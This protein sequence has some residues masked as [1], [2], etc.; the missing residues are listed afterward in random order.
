MDGIISMETVKE[1]IV[2]IV[3][4]QTEDSIYDEILKEIIFKRMIDKGLEDSRKRNLTSNEMM[5][6]RIRTWQQ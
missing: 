5:E 3:Q 4:L 6:H 1:K 2:G